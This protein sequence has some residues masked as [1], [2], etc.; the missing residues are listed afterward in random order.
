MLST[1]WYTSKKK[2]LQLHGGNQNQSVWWTAATPWWQP[3]CGVIWSGLHVGPIMCA[4]Q[5]FLRAFSNS[6]SILKLMRCRVN[7]F[8]VSPFVAIASPVLENGIV[9]PKVS[10][11]GIQLAVPYPLLSCIW[12]AVKTC[13]NPVGQGRQMILHR[14]CPTACSCGVLTIPAVNKM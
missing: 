9:S 6:K 1:L 3:T 7:Y 5:F 2:H 10:K 8:L 11:T 13:H 4:E 12:W 14:V